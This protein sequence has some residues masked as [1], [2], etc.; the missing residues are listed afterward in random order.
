[1]YKV[2]ANICLNVSKKMF[3]ICVLRQ[4]QLFSSGG[5]PGHLEPKTNIFHKNGPKWPKLSSSDLP[6]TLKYSTTLVTH[7]LC[8]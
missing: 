4:L 5:S 2:S 3:T 6:V 1:M 7:P 8:N